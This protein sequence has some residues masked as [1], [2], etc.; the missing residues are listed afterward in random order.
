MDE[1]LVQEAPTGAAHVRFYIRPVVDADATQNAGRTIHRDATYVEIS[2]P[3]DK[4]TVVD[5][6]L[7]EDD[8]RR[9]PKEWLAFEAN[10]SQE[11]AAG[12]LL[13][14]WGAISP[15]IVEDYRVVKVKTVEQLAALSDANVASLGMLGRTHRQMARDFLEAS[16]S[17]APLLR[18]QEELRQEREQ[19][20]ALEHVLKEQGDKLEAFIARGTEAKPGRM[21]PAEAKP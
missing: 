17:N 15:A 13:S 21:R 11:G 2:T 10:L 8:K 6:A 4:T 7:R 9:F 14:A 12:T 5:R 18:M 3:G 19:R 1:L 20:A 16:K